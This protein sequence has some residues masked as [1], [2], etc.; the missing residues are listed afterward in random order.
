MS[1][2]TYLT[3]KEVAKKLRL[4]SID[5]A[6]RWCLKHDVDIIFLGNKRVVPEFAFKLAYEQPLI[7]QFKLKYGDSWF[8]YYEAYKNQNIKTCMELKN[9]T[10]DKIVS[11]TAFNTDNF[12]NEIGYERP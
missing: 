12:L 8:S 9:K 7:D 6:V 11:S 3:L 4:K 5:S 1:Q 10:K 2:I